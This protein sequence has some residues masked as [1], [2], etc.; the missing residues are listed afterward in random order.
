MKILNLTIGIAGCG[1][2]GLPMMEVLL[3]NRI[4][5]FGHDIKE[6]SNF[7]SIQ[8]NFVEDKEKFFSQSDVIMFVV[9]DEQQTLSLIDGRGGIFES[10]NPK[11]LLICSTLS[12]RF[13]KDLKCRA[14]KSITLIDSPMSG[15]STGARA[16]K[17][18]FMVGSSSREFKFVSPLLKILGTN[19][20]H[21]GE[22][23]EGMSIKVLN[24]F[25]TS[26]S[27]VAVRQVL[28]Q[29]SLLNISENKLLK[30]MSCSSGQSWFGS[31]FENIEW[32][33]KGHDKDNTIGILEKDVEAYQD[34][35]KFVPE[36]RQT[37][38]FKDFQNAT[39]ESLRQLSKLV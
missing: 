22:F 6:R 11:T 15:A 2:M 14:P 21:I 13:I 33:K 17:L 8:G 26:A 34:A 24:N 39:I 19:I 28:A 37:K 32:A 4:K 20:H 31:N 29:A 3:K 10:R 5:A 18:T 7:S 25:V 1:E 35:I 36:T 30:I 27:V 16:A 23:G 9:R 12:P 38:E